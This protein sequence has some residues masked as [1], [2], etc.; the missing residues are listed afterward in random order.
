MT[1]KKE[2]T[3][4]IIE[5]CKALRLPSTRRFFE[6]EIAEA[7]LRDISYE[8]FL[9]NLL[10]KENDLR[11]ENGKKNRIRLANFPWKKY[12][13]DLMVEYLP[14]DARKKL[15][16]LSSLEFIKTGQNVILAGNPGTGKTHIAIGLGIKACMEGYKVLFTTVPLLINQLK[17][18]RSAKTLR[19]YENKFERYDLVIADEL[20]YISFDKEGSE[21]LFT[22]LSLRAGRKST[23]ITTN[24][25]F[26]RWDEIFMDPVMTAA[27][28]DRLTH[29][30]YMV[31]MNGN[32]YRLKET[33]DW[34]NSQK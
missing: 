1:T 21:L 6:T 18:S 27:M 22:N 23:I 17:E 11:Y 7:N 8:E 33:Q 31:N 4:L 28:I 29:K 25:S 34:L 12:L 13:E 24:L 26:E 10:Q 20:G 3:R 14:E 5:Y 32:S 15:K 2:M 9:F 16:T 30:S 19:A